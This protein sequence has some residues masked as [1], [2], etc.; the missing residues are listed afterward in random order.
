M[1]ETW[2]A[3]S[4]GWKVVADNFHLRIEGD[5]IGHASVD[6]A[7]ARLSSAQLWTPPGMRRALLARLPGYRLSKFEDCL[8]ERFALEII[9]N[10]LL[11][12]EA[13]V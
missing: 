1:Q 11:D 5:G 9:E 3:T 8:P 6:G 12:V 10:Y 13:T 4:E 7:V 2:G